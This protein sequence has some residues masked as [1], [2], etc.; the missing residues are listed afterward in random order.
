MPP[1]R[2]ELLSAATSYTRSGENR[3]TE[4]LATVL[5]AHDALARALFDRVGLPY[6]ERFE[7]RTQERVAPGCIPDLVV[8]AKRPA[9]GLVAQ[10][11]AEHKTVSGFR[12]EQR[13]DY[14]RALS[15]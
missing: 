13:E 7:V 2:R 12:H 4:I 14:H 11:W 9:G 5:E 3:L 10:L 1:A 15:T 6:G 8:R